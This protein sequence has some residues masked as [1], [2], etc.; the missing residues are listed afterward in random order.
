MQSFEQTLGEVQVLAL[1]R[2]ADG[3]RDSLPKRPTWLSLTLSG[4]G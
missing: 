4:W 3:R 1:I 2:P